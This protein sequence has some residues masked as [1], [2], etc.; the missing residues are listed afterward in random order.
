[1][2]VVANLGHGSPDGMVW[3]HKEMATYRH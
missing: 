2:L 1:V 3:L